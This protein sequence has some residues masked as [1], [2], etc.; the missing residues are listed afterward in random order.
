M[1]SCRNVND[2]FGVLAFSESCHDLSLAWDLLFNEEDVPIEF[3]V[4]EDLLVLWNRERSDSICLM[5]PN[6]RP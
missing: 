6:K 4:A 1:V 3:E 5:S 2:N